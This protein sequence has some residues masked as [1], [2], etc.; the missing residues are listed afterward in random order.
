M[1]RHGKV[2]RVRASLDFVDTRKTNED[3]P[4]GSEA[5]VN[6]EKYFPERVI[7]AP[8]APGDTKTA[9]VI[10]S[11]LTG[12]TNLAWRHSQNWNASADYAWT[13]CRGGTLEF[14]GRLLYFELYQRQIL[15]GTATVD[16]IAL[17]STNSTGLLRY[18]ANFG[19]GWSNRDFGFGID[20]RYYSPRVLPMNEW[21]AQGHDRIRP[22]WQFDAYI[23]SDLGRWLPWDQSRRGLRA[24][25]RVNN[26]FGD[27]FPK[28][29][30]EPSGA[31]VQPYG[32][33]RGRTY[34]LSLTASF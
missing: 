26:V 34:S 23:E 16:E 6:L 4:V 20:G 3:I 8:L 25:L 14:Y 13:E 10:T 19:A 30:S 17:P 9:G 33:W 1:F 31:G 22:A 12:R 28:Y 15:P 2:H 29:L 21:A 18:R 7:R 5:A 27:R 24:Q 11:V 32:D